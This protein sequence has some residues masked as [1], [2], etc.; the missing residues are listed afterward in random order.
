MENFLPYILIA[1]IS[2]FGIVIQS[3]TGFGYGIFVMAIYPLFLEYTDA[4]TASGIS[5]LVLTVF[6][7]YNH[8][9]HI[10]FKKVIIPFIG[11][12][13]LSFFGTALLQRIYVVLEAD[14]RAQADSILKRVLGLL[15]IVLSLYLVFFSDK[16]KIK[17]T[18]VNGLVAGGLGGAMNSLFGM[19]GPPVVVYFLSITESNLV[20][21]ACVQTYFLIGNI[22][23]TG[24]RAF[25][26]LITINSLWYSL[27]AL[28]TI[29]PG[30][31]VGKKIFEKLN[32]K[33]L[34]YAVYGFM[35]VM[36]VYFLI[37]G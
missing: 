7:V 16:V 12:S 8:R 10:Q 25:N 2:F 33:T 14:A 37:K 3:S 35:I 20:Y 32:P 6:H 22:Y 9:K 11:Y 4:L 1:I 13:V 29:A 21:L 34:R 19:G 18:P 15:L 5:A 28:V 27:A 17:P 36:G 24:L 26:G 23:A 30:M 31:I